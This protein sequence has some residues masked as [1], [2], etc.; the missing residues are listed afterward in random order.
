[1]SRIARRGS[2]KI[3]AAGYERCKGEAEKDPSVLGENL[4]LVQPIF[5]HDA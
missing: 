1:M 3:W 2:S 5:Q 4:R